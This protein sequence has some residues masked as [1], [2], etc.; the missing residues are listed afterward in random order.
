[1]LDPIDWQLHPPCCTV[2]YPVSATYT[3]QI[4]E[5]SADNRARKLLYTRKPPCQC[6]HSDI[7][8]A[9][10]YSAG[11]HDTQFLGQVSMLHDIYVYTHD[12]LYLVSMIDNNY[13][14]SLIH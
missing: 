2:Q 3:V 11:I 10:I 8:I 14:W 5:A 7:N 6:G 4:G 1:M 12:T 9:G 13:V